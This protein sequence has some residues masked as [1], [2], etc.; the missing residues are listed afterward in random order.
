M[1]VLKT[2]LR[3]GHNRQLHSLAV[4]FCSKRDLCSVD[5][6]ETSSPRV[7]IDH[8]AFRFDKCIVDDLQLRVDDCHPRQLQ[9]L[10]CVTLFQ[11]RRKKAHVTMSTKYDKSLESGHTAQ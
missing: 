4:K 7:V 11:R 6:Q 9:A 5:L 3:Q 1:P 2:H 8:F 10:L